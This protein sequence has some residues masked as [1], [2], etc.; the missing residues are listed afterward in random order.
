MEKSRAM[1]LCWDCVLAW[2]NDKWILR[3]QDRLAGND[4]HCGLLIPLPLLPHW[5]VSLLQRRL[6]RR[7]GFPPSR[8]R[9]VCGRWYD[10]N[11]RRLCSR[12]KLQPQ[13]P[14]FWIRFLNQPQFPRAIPFLKLLLAGNGGMHVFMH[15]E[16]DEQMHLMLLG[17]STR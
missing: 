6:R 8:E 15:L 1:R 5:W 7:T 2:R 13:I 3:T 11:A 4:L 14:P 16:I 12:T 17:K 9:R 10:L